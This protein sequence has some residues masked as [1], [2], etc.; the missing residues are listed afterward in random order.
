MSHVHLWQLWEGLRLLKQGRNCRHECERVCQAISIVRMLRHHTTRSVT[1]QVHQ[2]VIIGLAAQ[3]LPQGNRNNGGPCS[4]GLALEDTPPSRNR[5]TGKAAGAW[6]RS[7]VQAQGALRGAVLQSVRLVQ[8]HGAPG[9]ALQERAVQL[10][11]LAVALEQ[12][13]ARQQHVER[14]RAAVRL[15]A[16][17][18]AR[19]HSVNMLFVASRCFKVALGLLCLHRTKAEPSKQSLLRC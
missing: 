17:V 11:L 3:T 16:Q 14:R 15:P 10:L 7:P 8:D 9:P 4:I 12:R 1:Y 6:G 13:V 2:N 18:C 5:T 19:G